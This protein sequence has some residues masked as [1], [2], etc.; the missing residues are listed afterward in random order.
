MVTI[1]IWYSPELDGILLLSD[2]GKYWKKILEDGGFVLIDSF[3][4]NAVEFYGQKFE[5]HKGGCY[6]V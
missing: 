1:N 5:S 6:A 3:E 2:Q 4:A